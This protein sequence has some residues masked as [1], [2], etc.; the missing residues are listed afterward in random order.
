MHT[1]G[2][3]CAALLSDDRLVAGG[4]NGLSVWSLS[5]GHCIQCSEPHRRSVMGVAVVDDLI[6]SVS[7]VQT[8]DRW[9][10]R[11]RAIE[12]KLAQQLGSQR[13]CGDVVN[14]ITKFL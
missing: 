8:L 14:F 4:Y 12:K 6:I 10:D 2:F 3:S 7:G 13:A 9:V 1:V 5:D 11:Q